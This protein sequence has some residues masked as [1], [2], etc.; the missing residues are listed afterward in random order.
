MLTA[1]GKAN[2][3]ESSFDSGYATT[4]DSGMTLTSLTPAGNGD[5]TATV[6]FTSRQ[7]P[8]DSVDDSACNN[9]TV[10]LSLVP[11]GTG[12]LISPGPSSYTDC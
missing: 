7:S 2:Q 5:L 8:S 11:D 3:P 9:W 1:Q 6:A 10:N 4:T 12:Y